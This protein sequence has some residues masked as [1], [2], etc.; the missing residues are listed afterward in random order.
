M[1]ND[2]EYN[3][4]SQYGAQLGRENQPKVPR[5][6]TGKLRLRRVRLDSGGYDPGGAYWGT[7]TPLYCVTLDDGENEY[8][9][10]FRAWDRDTVKAKFP[11]ASFYR[12][13][14]K[15]E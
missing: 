11:K 13:P 8:N 10:Y 1:K 6:T 4:S 3:G 15:K 2:Y 5:D 9:E 14:G 7:G 12:I